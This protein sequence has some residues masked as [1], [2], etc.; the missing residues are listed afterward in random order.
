M[1]TTPGL[2]VDLHLAH[3]ATV[4]EGDGGRGE[5]RRLAEPGLHAGGELAWLV[6]DPG[7]GVE[8]HP[9]ISAGDA[10]PAVPKHDVFRCGLQHAG[11]DAAAP[12]D[13]LLRRAHHGRAADGEG[14]RAA[15]A[16]TGAERIGIT[17]EHL[18]ALRGDPQA[19]AHDLDEGGFVALPH[20]RGAGEEGYR[21]IRVD[22]QL[23][24]VRVDRRVGPAGHLD[25][26]GDSE[27]A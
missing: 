15:V 17:R 12:L 11:R 19:I 7:Y 22:T 1:R 8:G 20:R 2:G 25:G 21:A 3:L 9:A 6:G 27:T 5:G 4:G 23:S 13:D 10:E 24:R 16:S 26:V 18:D 14:A